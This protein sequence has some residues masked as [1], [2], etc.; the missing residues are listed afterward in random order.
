MTKETFRALCEALGDQSYDA[1]DRWKSLKYVS[2][3]GSMEP[4]DFESLY[5]NNKAYFI[6]DDSIGTGFLMLETPYVEFEPLNQPDKNHPKRVLTF[7]GL[8]M[9]NAISFRTGN[10]DTANAIIDSYNEN[11]NSTEEGGSIDGAQ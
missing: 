2:T 3:E 11:N 1:E 5:I 6:D 10:V 9:V 7:M 4:I 8:E